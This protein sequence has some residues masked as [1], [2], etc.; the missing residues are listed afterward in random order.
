MSRAGKTG[1]A[2]RTGRRVAAGA[3]AAVALAVLLVGCGGEGS[4]LGSSFSGGGGFKDL[5]GIT[6]ENPAKAWLVNNVDG[7]PNLVGLCVKGVAFVTTTR[8][9]SAAALMRVPEWDDECGT[10]R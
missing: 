1:Q 10:A 5:R 2:G 3:G 9:Q 6:P 7:Y 8:D 4:D